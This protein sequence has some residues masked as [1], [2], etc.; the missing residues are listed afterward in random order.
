MNII[1]ESP[2]LKFLISRVKIFQGVIKSWKANHPDYEGRIEFAK[3]ED[4]GNYILSLECYKE[5]SEILLEG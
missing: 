5:K 3:D 2:D 1:L 4:T